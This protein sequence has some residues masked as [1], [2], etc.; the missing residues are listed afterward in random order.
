MRFFPRPL[1]HWTTLLLVAHLV[2]LHAVPAAAGLMPSRVSGT[3]G[4][5][6]A[7]DAELLVVQRVL[8][9]K[10]VAQKLRDY[11]LAVE[12]VRARLAGLS[13]QELHQ[14]A[15]AAHGLPSGSD[16]L[17]TLVTLL[18]IVILVIVIL[19]LLNKEIVIK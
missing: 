16:G 15:S 13:D 3:T 14:L 10:I 18:V 19:K 11:G 5:E 12:Q 8:E 7:R 9:H 4:L 2:A 1:R 6:S 17:G